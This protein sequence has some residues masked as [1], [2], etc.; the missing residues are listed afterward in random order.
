MADESLDDAQSYNASSEDES[1]EISDEE[2]SY[3][4]VHVLTCS[5]F[6]FIS[7]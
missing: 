5:L 2:Q 6:W 3:E 4:H 7:V 1:I